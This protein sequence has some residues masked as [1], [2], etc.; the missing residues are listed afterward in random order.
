MKKFKK[1][2]IAVMAVF[3][4]SSSASSGDVKFD[5]GRFL[6]FDKILSGNKNISC[7][8]C[9]HPTLASGD[10]LSLGIG[11]GGIGLGTQRTAV[12]S[13]IH[14]VPRNSPALFNVGQSFITKYFH[15]GRVERD[16][17]YPSGFKSPA[18]E[19]LPDGLDSLLAAQSLFPIT[20]DVEMTGG[21]FE[22]TIGD[23][24]KEKNFKKIWYEIKT[25]LISIPEYLELFKSSFSEVNSAADVKIAHYA[26]AIS[27]FQRLAFEALN[28]PFDEYLEGNLSSLSQDQVEGMNLFYGKAKCFECHRGRFQTDMKFHS[29][30]LPPVGP[31]KGVGYN[32]QDDFGRQLVTS[33][34]DDKYK[35]RTPSLRNVSLTAP[36]GH[37]GAYSNLEKIIRHHLNPFEM[38]YSYNLSEATLPVNGAVFDP[39]IILRNNY[40]LNQIFV[41][42]DLPQVELADEEIAKIISFLN[43]LTDPTSLNLNHLIPVSVPSNLPV[44][45]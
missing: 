16:F 34:R 43:G 5:L 22:N 19:D 7:A 26:N 25:R 15:D 12:N 14:L 37:N 30:A 41:T 27:H 8:S 23:A 3:C 38:L 40:H 6:F 36:Y 17:L 33:D 31:G 42:H 45:D 28:S 35:F 4:L 21:E 18:D 10:G 24:S 2:L 39:E 44:N 29:I 32:Y 13:L 20:S 1:L 11:E 9:H